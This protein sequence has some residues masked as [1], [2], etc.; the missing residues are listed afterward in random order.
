ML[1]IDFEEPRQ[2]RYLAVPRPACFL[3]MAVGA[4]VIED[5]G[6]GWRDPG[7]GK[8]R[9]RGAA[10]GV[11]R[12]WMHEQGSEQPEESQDC[13]GKWNNA[14]CASHCFGMLR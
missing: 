6:Q 9:R 14:V 11:M 12:E 5:P 8:Q 13:T 2:G 1:Y 3:R 7:S 10:G 4:R